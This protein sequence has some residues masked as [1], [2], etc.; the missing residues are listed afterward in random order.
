VK[1]TIDVP[2]S[3]LQQ[4][5]TLAEAQGISVEELLARTI[6]ENLHCQPLPPSS[7]E[8]PW[9]K[10]FGALGDIKEENARILRLIQEEFEH[11]E[12]EDRQ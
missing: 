6:E 4:A 11:I 9:M 2:T 3:T 12:P 1:T 7:G 5:K 10:G 8:R